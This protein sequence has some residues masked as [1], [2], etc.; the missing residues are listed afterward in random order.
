MTTICPRV[1]DMDDCKKKPRCAWGECE[2]QSLPSD[3]EEYCPSGYSFREDY[4]DCILD[5]CE[6]CFS[7]V[8]WKVSFATFSGSCSPSTKQCFGFGANQYSLT[9]SH[10]RG[11]SIAFTTVGTGNIGTC[12]GE[13]STTAAITKV[14]C[15]NNVPAFVTQT[16]GAPGCSV[17]FSSGAIATV[18]D[19]EVI[20]CE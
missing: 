13:E 4:C 19:A 1:G 5:T 2:G 14:A 18:Y 7:V 17:N 3:P 16:I 11:T 15:V 20:Y 12:N 10:A 6:S 9:V 8:K